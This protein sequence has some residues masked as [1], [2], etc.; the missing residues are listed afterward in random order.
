M[1]FE[2]MYRRLKMTTISLSE[3]EK[4]T[5]VSHLA[6][7]D[8]SDSEAYEILA[9]FNK[10]YRNSSLRSVKNRIS[11]YIEQFKR[12]NK[13]NNLEVYKKR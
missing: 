5:I 1:L 4:I 10:I 12:V 13:M 8:V 11:V 2:I 6:K 7:L 9:F 3:S